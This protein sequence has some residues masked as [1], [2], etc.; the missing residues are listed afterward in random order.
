VF[1]YGVY[2]PRCGTPTGQAN[3][4]KYTFS[5]Q[6]WANAGV[7]TYANGMATNAN[8][9]G[10]GSCNNAA[11]V[12]KD[13]THWYYWM[14]NAAVLNFGEY[15][16]ATNTV[17]RKA[18]DAAA[19]SIG[20]ASGI[21]DP[22]HDATIHILYYGSNRVVKVALSGFTVTDTAIDASCPS[23]GVSLMGFSYDPASGKG[24]IFPNKSTNNNTG[25][26]FYLMD[27][28]T[29][30]CSSWSAPGD[31]IAAANHDGSGNSNGTFGRLQCGVTINGQ[32]NLCVL[33]N[34]YNQ[35]VYVIRTQ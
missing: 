25:N 28:S 7:P 24:L 5:S 18:D 1:K 19:N 3:V 27:T 20:G 31:S 30:T 6:T 16:P 14:A 32:T 26:T 22:V 13:S 35:P 29:L 10:T 11:L 9:G 12:R 8:C 2:F 15:N 23:V 33:L 17:T 4:W 34:D 21:Y